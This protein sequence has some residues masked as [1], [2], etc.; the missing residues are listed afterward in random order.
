MTQYNRGAA[1]ERQTVN[2]LRAKGFIAERIAGSHSPADV[3]AFRRGKQPIFIQC[4]RNGVL[5][6]AEWNTFLDYCE[7]AG[8]LPVMAMKPKRGIDYFLITGKKEKRGK[9]PMKGIELETY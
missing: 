8:A 5:P 9:Q 6:P 2:D 7:Q 3:H 1:F 4:K